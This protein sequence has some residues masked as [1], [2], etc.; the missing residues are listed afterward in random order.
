M[1]GCLDTYSAHKSLDVVVEIS[2]LTLIDQNLEPGL[3]NA[4]E[5][6]SWDFEV[7]SQNSKTSTF[8]LTFLFLP[9]SIA[10]Y[11]NV[12]ELLMLARKQKM[13]HQKG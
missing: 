7:I 11:P 12:R 8:S 10:T 3:P 6:G 1:Q 13:S 2:I 5:V 4:T 9:S